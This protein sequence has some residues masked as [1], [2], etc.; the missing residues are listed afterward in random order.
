MED[1]DLEPVS[2]TLEQALAR[3]GSEIEAL[4][5]I[6]AHH[7]ET[8][9]RQAQYD[10]LTATRDRLLAE[11]DVLPVARP[12]YCRKCG[13]PCFVTETGEAHHQLL[14]YTE[15]IIDQRWD[16]DHAVVLASRQEGQ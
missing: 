2:E 5:Q 8:E 9:A 4:C 7:G 10:R 11:R 1:K 16:D 14:P 15:D 12:D 13:R 3:V 6:M